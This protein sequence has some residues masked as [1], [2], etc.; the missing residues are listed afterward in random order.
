MLL[1]TKKDQGII[2]HP[3]LAPHL[4]LVT[5][6]NT[7]FGID[8][9]AIKENPEILNESNFT[10]LVNSK[11]DGFHLKGALNRDLLQLIDG[12]RSLDEIIEKLQ[13]TY[14][15]SPIKTILANLAYRFV[16]VSAEHNVDKDLSAIW[17][18]GGVTPSF[19]ENFVKNTKFHC[20]S[21]NDNKTHLKYLQQAMDGFSMQTT[22]DFETADVFLVVVDDYLQTELTAFNQERLKDKKTWI[23][24]KLTGV[25][26]MHGPLFT[27][28]DNTVCL[29]CITN[30]MRNNKEV[31]GFLEY[32]KSGSLV[33]KVELDLPLLTQSHIPTMLIDVVKSL[34]AHANSTPDEINDSPYKL[35]NNHIFSHDVSIAKNEQHFTN[36]R[37]QCLSCGDKKLYAKDR[38]PE[39][40]RL[41]DESPN[42]VFTSGGMK[43]T[44]ARQT[45]EKYDHLIS[46]LTG[47]ITSIE[48]SSPP[49]DPW[50]HVYWS[51][52]NLA[53]VNR[54]FRALTNSIR[55]KSAGKGRSKD[56]A[57]VSAMCEALERY[58][59]VYN[60][61]EIRKIA[62][63]SDF[64]KGD[65]LHPNDLMLF[66][67]TQYKNRDAISRAGH[68]FYALPAE[69]F[70]ENAELEWSPVWSISQEKFIWMMCYQLYFSYDPINYKLNRN[71][72][73]PDS[74]GA[75]SGNTPAEAF[76]QGF[77]ELI[78]RDAYAIWWYNRLSYPEVDLSSFN[79][80]YLDEAIS[81][82]AK[83]YNRKLWVLDITND[84]G[85]PVFV[86]LSY[87]FD[88]EK[89]DICVSAGAH[90]DPH[91]A[92]LRAVCELNQYISA[93]LKS[94]DE[95]DSYTYFDK[96]C[97][98]WWQ[99]A[100]LE[101]DPY[102]LPD[103]NAK[104]I[105]KADYPLVDRNL[106]EE[107]QA[108]IDAV[109]EKGLEIM[110]LNQTRADVGLPVMK[111]MV[112]GMR[113]FWARFAPGRLFEVPVTMGKLKKPL[114]E[115][116]LNPTPVFI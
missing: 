59:G 74:N 47:I 99:N 69:D 111:V 60:G 61:D 116:D 100:T 21:L 68:R 87:R 38:A 103:A 78:E 3:I 81:R 94:T 109:H 19:Y 4:E 73:N 96:E 18:N 15:E 79:D 48:I 85:I 97:N 62:K 41:F 98:D 10:F 113:H 43:A 25:Q 71:F 13:P 93:V 37:P 12:K 51:G 54:N 52:S 24:I 32:N 76:V 22:D 27:P 88:K 92:A 14:S 82:Y 17:T 29:D 83:V 75:A 55:S 102:L 115:K 91:I 112:P 6:S 70:D 63:F 90:F 20:V 46:P 42:S 67:D 72:A 34:F 40:V 7:E 44:S 1:K 50:M 110:V 114:A 65:A 95:P 31:R 58:S 23:P 57:K 89:Q 5:F 11:G 108:C 106:N 28:K 9:A 104:A 56:Q 105:T 86:A 2:Q 64:K 84:F 45:L 16:L 77:M 49:D 36:K 30:N 80:P 35:I 107:V 8:D 26:S 39:P 66:S 53:I 101:T 33:S